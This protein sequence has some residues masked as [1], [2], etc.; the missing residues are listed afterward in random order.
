MC[1][2]VAVGCLGKSVVCPLGSV[3]GN[4]EN[5]TLRIPTHRPDGILFRIFIAVY[6]VG[7]GYI[8]ELASADNPLFRSIRGTFPKHSSR[9]PRI[10]QRLRVVFSVVRKLY[11]TET[12]ADSLRMGT[13]KFIGL[14]LIPVGCKRNHRFFVSPNMSNLSIMVSEKSLHSKRVDI[15]FIKSVVHRGYIYF[16][17]RISQM[18]RRTGETSRHFLRRDDT[19]IATSIDHV[20]TYQQLI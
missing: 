17:S 10:C 12:R 4:T 20:R 6:S 1:A 13:G 18:P 8:G 15:E 2:I 19:Y 11:A 5:Y 3:C 7:G 9:Y 14:C 16:I